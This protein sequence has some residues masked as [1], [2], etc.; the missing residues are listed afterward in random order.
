MVI[1]Q[2]HSIGDLIFI[3]PICRYYFYKTGKMPIVP[4]HD[5]LM[6]IQDYI[7][8]AAFVPKSVFELDYESLETSNPDYLPLLYANQI[9][10]ELDKYDYSDY[11]NVML[12]KYR[13]ALLAYSDI[14]VKELWKTVD[15]KF[16]VDKGLRLFKELE[17]EED[18]R[19]VLVN[20]HSRAGSI[21]IS[22]NQKIR[23][24]VYMSE[25]EGYTPIDWWKVMLN[26]EENHHISTCTFFIL[27]ALYNKIPFQSQ[28]FLY[29][30]PGEDGLRGIKNLNPTY[31]HVKLF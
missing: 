3:E 19:Y 18:T 25:R 8:S 26:A 27:Q 10:R 6:W 12:D 31:R 4:I 22:I 16:D 14:G 28:V 9:I 5:H 15:L 29:P 11:E 7:D 1:N 13:L 17:L 21:D 30:R 2:F 23:K 20:Q 24:V